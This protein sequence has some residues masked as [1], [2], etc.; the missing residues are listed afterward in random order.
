MKNK[1]L[2]VFILL[3]MIQIKAQKFEGLA[4]TPP[5]G[6]NSWTTFETNITEQLIKQTADVLVSSG[7]KDLGY[8][9]LVLDDGWMAM[10]RDSITGD[11]VP[12]P[13]KFPNG[14]K[15]VIDYV[16]AKGLKFGLYNC[17]GDKT[18]GG[19]PGTRGYE[20]QDA[21]YYAAL[22][23]DYFK[24]DWCNTDGITAK[25][26]YTTMSKALKAAGRPIVFSLCEWGFSKPW[27]WAKEVGQLW[28]SAGDVGKLFDGYKQFP[29][30]QTLGM[31]K[32]LDLQDTLYKYSGPG[33]WN[34]ADL[35]QVGTD[36]S[37]SEDKAFFSAW[38]ML[39]SPL[40]AANDIRNMSKET[41]AI[42]T[43]KEAID[44]DQDAGAM[45][46]F[47]YANQDS[48]QTWFRPLQNGDW[49]VCFINRGST[50]KK[51]SFDW[52]KETVEND[53]Y[54]KQLNASTVNYQLYDLWSKK[55]IGS[56]AKPLNAN[57]PAHDVI[58]LRLKK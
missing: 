11:L 52:G 46:A 12:D 16:H 47:R 56:T 49:A 2:F 48:L 23:I 54:K 58:W 31:M 28:R 43:N 42:L 25:E 8:T 3:T 33:H 51:V 36:M 41:L 21:R 50:A 45:Q 30:W 7:M 24:Y 55:I 53:F 44:I 26:A 37:Y 5:M 20:Y 17:A 22:K 38:C 1:L 6:W 14:L 29:T 9:Y 32:V 19:Y 4:Q 35:L 18:C 27:E 15:P 10:Q 40:M 34:D 13:K 39:A 57:L